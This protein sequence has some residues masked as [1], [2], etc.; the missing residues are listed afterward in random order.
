MRE[1]KEETA[2]ARIDTQGGST[3]KLGSGKFNPRINVMFQ[4]L[5]TP[6]DVHAG[7]WEGFSS[8]QRA[9]TTEF[10]VIQSTARRRWRRAAAN[11][12]PITIKPNDVHNGMKKPE[13][14]GTPELKCS[15]SSIFT[16]IR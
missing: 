15:M 7:R 11:A 12:A 2:V 14:L 1:E 3:P 9:R 8:E 5:S 10:N 16:P 4:V 6:C 13:L